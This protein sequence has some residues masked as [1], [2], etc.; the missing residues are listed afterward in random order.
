MPSLRVGG[1][2][3]VSADPVPRPLGRVGTERAAKLLGRAGMRLVV[4]HL[5]G[6]C[7]VTA[8]GERALRRH[9]NGIQSRSK[10]YP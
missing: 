5:G 4:C 8:V 9:D 6:G 2:S 3:G 1:R 7:S 10:A